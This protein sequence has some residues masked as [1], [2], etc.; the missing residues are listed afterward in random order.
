MTFACDGT[1]SLAA[2]I[3]NLTDT[4]ID[5]TGHNIIIR[6]TNVTGLF[7]V[8]KVSLTLINLTVADGQ[9]QSGAG[10]FNDG[11][12]L[13]LENVSFKNNTVLPNAQPVLA[14]P[15]QGGAVYTRDGALY[16][17]NCVFLN[18]QVG[19]ASRRCL[20]RRRHLYRERSGDPP[21]LPLQQQLGS[22]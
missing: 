4:V 19:S 8:S 14:Q 20:W 22:G 21:R 7:Y 10:V 9:A 3:T 5:A 2:P 18:N 15:G 13:T 1:I 17:T 6:G 11:G 16:A 12:I